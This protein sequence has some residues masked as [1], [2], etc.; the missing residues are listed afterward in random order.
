MKRIL[1]LL[2]AACFSVAGA[3]QSSG[4]AGAQGSSSSGA[5]AQAGGAQAGSGT[6]VGASGNA[7][8]R[9]DRAVN[10]GAQGSAGMDAQANAG[11]ASASLSSDTTIDAELTKTVDARKAKAG[12][13]VAARVRN[14]VKQDGKVVLRRGTKLIGHVT[15]AQAKANGQANSQLGIIFDR[16][17]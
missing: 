12:D 4:S 7:G 1:V 13:Q 15:Q 11:G 8:Q 6:T 9:T 10:S 2:A 14:D 17:E 5:A 3:A 16:A